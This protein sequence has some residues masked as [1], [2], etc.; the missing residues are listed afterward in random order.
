MFMRIVFGVF[1]FL[2]FN[3]SAQLNVRV[4]KSHER[5]I[6]SFVFSPDGKYFFTGGWD[7]KIIQW[8]TR[9]LK[10]INEFYGHGSHVTGLALDSKGNLYSVSFGE[11]FKWDLKSKKYQKIPFRNKINCI[12]VISEELY[13][14]SGNK[15]YSYIDKKILE[16]SNVKKTVIDFDG[17]R[18]HFWLA[19]QTEV[20]RIN[21]VDQSIKTI[22]L[23]KIDRIQEIKC[24]NDIVLIS[25][26]NQVYTLNKED[27]KFEVYPN[28]HQSAALSKTNIISVPYRTSLMCYTN[29]VSKD[30]VHFESSQSVP[31]KHIELSPQDDYVVGYDYNALALWDVRTGFK[32]HEFNPQRLKIN[33]IQQ[34][35]SALYFG[36]GYNGLLAKFNLSYLNYEY[37]QKNNNKTVSG[38]HLA[39]DNEVWSW[40]KDNKAF[41]FNEIKKTV[42]D[43]INLSHPDSTFAAYKNASGM[44]QLFSGLS[45]GVISGGI[46]YDASK[47]ILFYD[48]D[49]RILYHHEK[50]MTTVNHHQDLVKD[51]D[52]NTEMTV[53]SA[54]LDKTITSF[55]ANNTDAVTI[56]K[57]HRDRVFCVK[58]VDEEH[59]LS[60]GADGK[61]FL[62]KLGHE[63][64]LKT[65]FSFTGTVYD[66][67]VNDQFVAVA[68]QYGVSIRQKKD[69]GMLTEFQLDGA[70]CRQV[71]FLNDSLLCAR[72]ED[73]SI[74]FLHLSR[75]VLMHQ[76]HTAEGVVNYTDEGYYFG[77]VS[78]IKK[79]IHYTDEKGNVFLYDQLDHYFNRPDTL[80]ERLNFTAQKLIKAYKNAFYKR[81]ELMGKT[82]DFLSVH[83]Y[84]DVA[85]ANLNDLPAVSNENEIQLKL[86]L[87]SQA[88]KVVQHQVFVNNVPLVEQNISTYRSSKEIDVS[89]LVTLIPGKNKIDIKATDENGNESLKSSFWIRYEPKV[90]SQNLYLIAVG[91]GQFQQSEFNLKY[92]EK[93]A[94]DV[95]DFFKN[96]T[97]YENIYTRILTGNEVTRKQF[98]RLSKFLKGAKENDVVMVFIAGHGVL[99]QD[100]KYHLSTYDMDFSNPSDKGI[101]Y[102]AVTQ[103]M[104]EIRPI[105]K[106]LLMDA[107]HSGE[108]DAA[109]LEKEKEAE[110]IKDIAFRSIQNKY[111][112]QL[113]VEN[114]FELS[115][116]LFAD[117]R[118]G[119]GTNIISSAGGAEF[120]MESALW[121]NGLFTYCFLEGLKSGNADLNKDGK[122][123]LSEIKNYTFYNV[124]ALSKGLQKPTSRV[125]NDIIDF[126]IK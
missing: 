76:F 37:L 88:S 36:L 100:F 26:L 61:V 45:G 113:G 24:Y 19:S 90:I 81:L 75:G 102:D 38:V 2:V 83:S 5:M 107:C 62:W 69:F 29:S 77:D 13:W 28:I 66:L 108:F 67:D 117:L 14:T 72:N 57:A 41:L 91:A 23:P 22:P 80:M 104:S 31:V 3:V 92:P 20:F 15:L 1:I 10:S 25:G 7:K 71:F 70:P 112:M 40:G 33:Q 16:L 82:K 39:T 121:R 4:N 18:E 124:G 6:S 99:D 78:A 46:S 51:V 56:Y 79:Y 96:S 32:V 103:L 12:Q 84:P 105:R 53:I 44:E 119:S 98:D 123:L 115:K 125:E 64:P 60:G 106:V 87:K 110:V 116:K 48:N 34:K 27:L 122:I 49:V 8:D 86:L 11:V 55:N 73:E 35:D 94:N 21:K 58:F 120:A 109:Y 42:T 52:V 74:D 47:S 9:S 85:I 50:K 118:Y 126:R 43:S 17:D 97:H 111:S 95:A 101:S 89:Q 54:S 93:D 63:E 68:H 114:S 59:F 30:S 65:V